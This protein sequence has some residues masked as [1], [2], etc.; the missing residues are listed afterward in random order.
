MPGL[1]RIPV[2]DL[3]DA[4]DGAGQG[5]PLPPRT[6]RGDLEHAIPTR[7]ARLPRRRA[8]RVFCPAIS[9]EES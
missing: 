9:K 8:A 3:S 6:R 1:S 5:I 7:A 4:D 2:R